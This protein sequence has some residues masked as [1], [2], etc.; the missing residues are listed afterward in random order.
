MNR[1]LIEAY[2]LGGVGAVQ[3][4]FKEYVQPE[5]TA[6]RGWIAIAVGVTA[7]ELACP[8]NELL[9]EGVD[10]AIDKH[11]VAIPLAI[12]YVAAHLCNL[13]PEKLDLFTQITK[14]RLGS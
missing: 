1:E 10:R 5:L 6:R 4:I 7:Y 13:L 8:K 11:P 14:F 3:G 9:S 2:T 12:G